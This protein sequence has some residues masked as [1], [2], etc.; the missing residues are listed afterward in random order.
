M[1]VIMCVFVSSVVWGD[2]FVF[3]FA[4]GTQETNIKALPSAALISDGGLAV[5]MPSCHVGRREAAEARGTFVLSS[6]GQGKA[7]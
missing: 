7:V 5:K 2:F 1:M 3:V 4:D 6:A